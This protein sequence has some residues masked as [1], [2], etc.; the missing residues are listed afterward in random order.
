MKK[1]KLSLLALIFL[2]NSS[3][4]VLVKK[5]VEGT[6]YINNSDI[7][8]QGQHGELT[9]QEL[10]WSKTAWK[11]F[12]TNYNQQTGLVNSVESQTTT[13][14]WFTA[15]YIAALISAH[16]LG[17]ITDFNFYNKINKLLG[18]LNTMPLFDNKLPSNYYDTSTGKII[19]TI[20]K[21]DVEGWSAKDIGRLLIWLKIL[22]NLYPNTSEYVDKAVLR[23]NFC[24]IID[25]CGIVY[26]YKNKELYEEGRIGYQDYFYKGFQLWDFDVEKYIKSEKI[27][28][29]RIYNELLPYD[30]RSIRETKNYSIIESEPYILN[31]LE[32]NWDQLSDNTSMDSS[33]SDIESFDL[34][35]KIYSLQEKRF[36]QDGIFTSKSSYYSSDKKLWIYDSIFSEGYSWNTI[37][38]KGEF[39]PYMSL[40]STKASFGMWALWKTD[41]TNE[42]VELLKFSYDL[43][44]GWFEGK[45]EQNNN[46]ERTTTLST[47][48][49]IL[50]SLF[51][52]KN[53][54]IY[55]DKPIK[56]SYYKAILK[57][58]FKRPNSCFYPDRKGC[59]N[60]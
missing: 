59:D 13:N 60:P 2:V 56:N 24:E 48:S 5:V 26:S 31:G 25:P 43:Q 44:K 36:S 14:M 53:G 23:W 52:K 3:C 35:K 40:V 57:D 51:Y 22:E 8:R 16:K 58:E 10:E 27:D 19:Q 45:Y 42:L 20:D 6:E 39:V 30:T 34:S 37:T 50:E 47:N 38:E 54:K 4:G 41:Y 1:Y 33:H 28:Y 32:F 18:F 17:I 29:V 49:L 21:Q 55:Y 15:D 12:E 11:Y 9:N 46:Y 7:F